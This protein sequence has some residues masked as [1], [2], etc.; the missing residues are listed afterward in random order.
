MGQDG[1]VTISGEVEVDK[2]AQ[3]R[4]ILETKLG[5]DLL[6]LALILH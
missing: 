2:F 4:L 6:V 5:N 1:F 3:N